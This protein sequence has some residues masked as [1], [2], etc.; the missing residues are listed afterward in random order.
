V[1]SWHASDWAVG[2]K[3]QITPSGLCL[4]TKQF[5]Q[6]SPKYAALPARLRA[7]I[8]AK[9]TALCNSLDAITARLSP[10]QKAILV[11]GYRLAVNALAQAGWLTPA[12]AATLSGLAGQL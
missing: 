7:T 6:G 2:R 5:V 1:Q 8:D 12:Q 11:L 10:Q 4:M 3:T 9:L